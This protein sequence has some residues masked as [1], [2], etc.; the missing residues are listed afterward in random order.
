MRIESDHGDLQQLRHLVFGL[1]PLLSYL[2]EQ[3]MNPGPFLERAVIP[4]DALTSTEKSFAPAQEIGF[5]TDVYNALSTPELGLLVG[6]RYHLS[7]YGMLGLAAI[8]SENLLECF[9]IF[10]DN[11][12]LTWTYFKV[13]VYDNGKCGYLE[14]EPVRDLGSC[15]QFM[16]DRDLS[17]A[18]R[19]ACDALG[20]TMPLTSV[21]FRH[22]QP[23]YAERY[24][25]LFG[26]PIHF[27]SRRNRLCFDAKWLYAELPEAEPGTSRIFANQC[28]DIVRKLKRSNSLV[29]H[30]RYLLLANDHVTPTLEAIS[31]SAHVSARTLQRRL[32]AEG[33]TF[34]EVLNDVRVNVASEFLVTTSSSIESI[35]EQLGYSDATAFSHAFKRL[36]GLTPSAFRNGEME[37]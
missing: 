33:T 1:N 6:P 15:L 23:D 16:I 2:R 32:A 3:G 8:S 5:T 9:R 35:S 18:Y 24:Q 28:S 25:N 37:K 21:E 17:A 10:L 27:G 7:S 31:K 4:R 22:D 29:E 30:I 19:I 34:Q 11:I 26:C 12:Q 20:Q 36:T 14:M 13:S